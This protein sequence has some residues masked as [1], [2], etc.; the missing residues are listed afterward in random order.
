MQFFKNNLKKLIILML[1]VGV[2]CSCCSCAV[3]SKAVTNDETLEPYIT[4]VQKTDVVI[5]CDKALSNIHATYELS[6]DAYTVCKG[7]SFWLDDEMSRDGITRL[8]WITSLLTAL[9]IEAYEFV[10]DSYSRF[11]DK[12][13]F[14]GSEY[15][16]A[17]IENKILGAG[18]T[19]FGPN[20][21][22][23][24]QYVSTT[25][26]NALGYTKNHKLSC[27]DYKQIKDKKQAAISVYL[28]YIKLDE[29]GNFNPYAPVTEAEVEEILS[30]IEMM[31]S[32]K[33]K[34]VMSFGDSIMHGDGNYK[35]GIAD[36]MAEKYHMTAVDY[37]VG[38]ATFGFVEDRNQ[39]SNQILS[40]IQKNETADIILLDGGSN[41]MRKVEIGCISEGYEYGKHGRKEFA[42]GMEYAL[43]L[44]Q[45]NYPLTPVL[46]I[47]AHNMDFSTED[48][49]IAYGNF[50][51]DICEKWGIEKIDLYSDSQFN[52]H[53]ADIRKKYTAALKNYP[54]GD[55]VHP[56][57]DGYYEYYIPMI[58]P[59]VIEILKQT[60]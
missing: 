40:A 43:G 50:A 45:D 20:T 4:D 36:I 27:N 30:Q 46:Y 16:V 14:E 47:R 6:D 33:G 35:V 52:A 55:S 60:Q 12:D 28:S 34:T 56:N 59:E 38:G 57:R 2:A 8:E 5:E 49:E 22:A 39:I 29:N 51:M 25:L 13:Y 21:L 44:L 15:F 41:D 23:T 1:T 11:G 31:K 26:V 54:E 53:D 42:Q 10:D 9:D 19:Q 18:G 7:Y 37:S 48:K 32:L 58:V 3:N 24:R 17:A